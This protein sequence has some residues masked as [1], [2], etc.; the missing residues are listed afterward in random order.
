MG[1]GVGVGVGVGSIHPEGVN[2]TVLGGPSTVITDTH[3][4]VWVTA[5]G[6]D[7]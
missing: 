4:V 2:V 3:G 7:S 6:V 5:V 1:V